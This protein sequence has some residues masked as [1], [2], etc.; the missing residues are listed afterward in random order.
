M[1]VLPQVLQ[2]EGNHRKTYKTT[3]KPNTLDAVDPEQPWAV[4]YKCERCQKRFVSWARL[5]KHILT[6][7]VP[8]RKLKE[9]KKSKIIWV[10]LYRMWKEVCTQDQVDSP[11][12]DDLSLN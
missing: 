9:G 1:R 4:M 11:F 12:K 7:R 3:P 10:P 6:Q 8:W 2:I 5:E